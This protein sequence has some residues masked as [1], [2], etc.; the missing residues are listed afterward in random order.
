MKSK[1]NGVVVSINNIKNQ[2]SQM[3]CVTSIYMENCTETER[4]LWFIIT[5]KQVT[6][7]W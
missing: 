7:V 4:G 2:K 6:R 5:Q 1:K 3:I